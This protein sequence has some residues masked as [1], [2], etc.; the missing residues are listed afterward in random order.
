MAVRKIYAYLGEILVLIFLLT[1]IGWILWKNF[2]NF[3]E[4]ANNLHLQKIAYINNELLNKEKQHLIELLYKSANESDLTN[5]LNIISK[6]GFV[7]EATLYS[8]T[9]NKLAQSEQIPSSQNS[10]Y[11]TLKTEII[12]LY[13]GEKV[14]GFLEVSAIDFNSPEVIKENE[15][16]FSQLYA[17][18]VILFLLGG[19]VTFSIYRYYYLMKF[20]NEIKHFLADTKNYWRSDDN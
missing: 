10:E 6:T 9:G 17:L 4:Q 13:K 14:Y 1:T 18:A 16:N 5:A 11:P 7:K 19:G 12:T 20:N 15:L 2:D 3:K 8:P